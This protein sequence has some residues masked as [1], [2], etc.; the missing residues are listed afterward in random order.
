[1]GAF[2]RVHLSPM[3]GYCDPVIDESGKFDRIRYTQF[4]PNSPKVDTPVKMTKMPLD[5]TF[6]LDSAILYEK[7]REI[8]E[9]SWKIIERLRKMVSTIVMQVPKRDGTRCQ[10]KWAFS[11]SG[12]PYP[13]QY[14]KRLL[15]RC[16]HH[17]ISDLINNMDHMRISGTEPSSVILSQTKYLKKLKN[18][19]QKLPKQDKAKRDGVINPQNYNFNQF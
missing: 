1:M 10:E 7:Y 17:F 4:G 12:M 5:I 19:A 16:I 18:D 11:A 6:H 3:N 9:K 13:L 2:L 14:K 8:F 15:P